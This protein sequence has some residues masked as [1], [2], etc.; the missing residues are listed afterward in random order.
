MSE[1]EGLAEGVGS[2]SG[3][4]VGEGLGVGS[5]EGEVSGV[6]VGSDSGGEGA[7]EP[8]RLNEN[9]FLESLRNS[10]LRLLNVNASGVPSVNTW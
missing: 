7:G 10:S 9:W 6:D 8:K 4:G 5:G 3:V 1:G 2:G